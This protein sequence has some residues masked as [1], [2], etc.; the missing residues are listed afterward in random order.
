M[1]SVLR[2]QVKRT[3]YIKVESAQQSRA[4][5]MTGALGIEKA[6]VQT[7]AVP[8]HNGDGPRWVSDD[9]G[10]DNHEGT[11]QEQDHNLHKTSTLIF[12][13]GVAKYRG[14]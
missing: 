8:D 5:N 10:G 2:P 6:A 14:I 13:G 12:D 7:A 1:G 3:Q 9:N 11:E 4:S